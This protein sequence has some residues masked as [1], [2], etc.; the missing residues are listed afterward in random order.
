MGLG[1]KSQLAVTSF[2]WAQRM[3]NG[4]HIAPRNKL[5]FGQLPLLQPREAQMT[6]CIAF[7]L[8]HGTPPPPQ[9]AFHFSEST[10]AKTAVTRFLAAKSALNFQG[11]G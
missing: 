6:P 1:D 8:S 11:R 7:G 4:A 2:S 3:S 10:L 5:D 9:R